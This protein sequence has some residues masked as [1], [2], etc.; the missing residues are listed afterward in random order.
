MGR[1]FIRQDTQIKNSDVY[2]DT[3]APTL[4]NFETNPAEIETD[5]NNVRSML[6]H[7]RDNQVGNWYDALTAAT[8]F[9]GGAVRGVQDSNQDLH[10]LER[11]RLLKRVANVGVDV[12]GGSGVQHVVLGMGELPSN[13]TAAVGAV[14]TLGTAVAQATSFGTASAT[15]I[16]AGGNA[17]QPKNLIRIVDGT[18]GDA[19][20]DSADKEIYGLLQT[21]SGSDGHT[22]TVGGTEEVQISFVV[23]NATND[24]LQLITAGDMDGKTFD[25]AAVERFA[26]DDLPEECFL[27]DNF[28]DAGAA[29]VTRQSGYDNQGTAIVAT[30]SN[31]TLDLGLGLTWEVGDNTSAGLL[32]FTEGSGGGTT[33]LSVGAAVDTYTNN[34]VVAS[35]TNGLTV[36]TSGNDIR[37]GIVADTIDT[38]GATDLRFDAGAELIFDDSYRPGSTW[39]LNGIRLADTSV[40]WDTFETQ[41]GEVSLL[42][43]INQAAGASARTKTVGVVTTTAAADVNVTGAGMS[44][45][46]DAQLADYSTVTFVTDVDVYLNGVLL[47]NGANA[48]ANHDVYPGDTPANG[49]VKFEFIV[50]ST[51]STPDQVTMVVYGA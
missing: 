21:E 46:L 50:K 36:N 35:F 19:I 48:A 15:D 10:E 23:R 26:L 25:Y 37:I 32:T 44:P 2:D 49:D 39:S 41:F 18:T 17:L 51:G 5:L 30:T 14:T 20:L 38:S 42:N 9:E 27:G 13:T 24:G 45:N 12:S 22:M 40:E 8:G 31:S 11:K 1:T 28:T 33:A 34:A 7:L 43:A 6:S 3:I 47:R 29:N 4:A 16:V